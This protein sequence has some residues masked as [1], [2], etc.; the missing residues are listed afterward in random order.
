MPKT[1]D[2]G[3]FKKLIKQLKTDKFYQITANNEKAAVS[4]L[5]LK[6]YIS[7]QKPKDNKRRVFNVEAKNSQ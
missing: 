1:A 7:G 4:I 5:I 6:K 2:L 3:K